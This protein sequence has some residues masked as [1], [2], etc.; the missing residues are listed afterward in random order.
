MKHLL[1]VT[2]K[3]AVEGR[4]WRAMRVVKKDQRKELDATS[5]DLDEIVEAERALPSDEQ[6]LLRVMLDREL[7]DAE[8][9]RCI[10][11]IHSVRGKYAHLPTSS[12]D[13]AR[14]KATEI[15][16]EDRK[17]LL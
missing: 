1:K 8:R 7:Q 17:G 10:A 11:L 6:R 13:F 9:V 12:E 4:R 14:L 16:I 2:E 3:R 15:T 5:H